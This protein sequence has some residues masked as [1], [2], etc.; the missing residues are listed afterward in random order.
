MH[1]KKDLRS[2]KLF[3]KSGVAVNPQTVRIETVD[4][5]KGPAAMLGLISFRLNILPANPMN[6]IFYEDHFC[7]LYVNMTL[8]EPPGG[9]PLKG[10]L[11]P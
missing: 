6:A 1:K 8:I 3:R 7:Y 2:R 9:Y 5:R 11:M 10:G 4:K